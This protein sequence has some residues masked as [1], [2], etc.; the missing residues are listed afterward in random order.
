M[1]DANAIIIASIVPSIVSAVCAIYA[2][3]VARRAHQQL[4]NMEIAVD[5]VL[6]AKTLVEKEVSRVQ[7]FNAGVASQHTGGEPPDGTSSPAE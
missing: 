6:A 1:T 2:H 5:G 3:I 4:K 7:G